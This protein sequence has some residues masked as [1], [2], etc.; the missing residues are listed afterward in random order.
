MPAPTPLLMDYHLRC[1]HYPPVPTA[2]APACI[3]AI[4]AVE[5]G[6]SDA[7]IVTVS[8]IC[9]PAHDLVESYHLGEFIDWEAIP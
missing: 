8:G 4:E 5:R 1:N 7:Q 9:V 3:E 6:E 2:A